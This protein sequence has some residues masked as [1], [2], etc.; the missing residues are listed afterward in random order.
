MI[1]HQALI[2]FQ[3]ALHRKI[4]KDHLAI[5]EYLSEQE[6]SVN[7]PSSSVEVTGSNALPLNTSFL[8][9]GIQFKSSYV[10]IF[11]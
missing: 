8:K 4:R 1:A 7:V 3:L 2:I 11:F 10:V 9:Y 6:E 5:E